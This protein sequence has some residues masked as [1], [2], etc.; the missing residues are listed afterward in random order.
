MN[1]MD[2][3]I[4]T[5]QELA[6]ECI[7]RSREAR[8]ERDLLIQLYE[9]QKNRY[10]VFR[11]T[12]FD[13]ILAEKMY[14]NAVSGSAIL[15]IRYWRTGRHIP[16]DREQVLRF[17]QALGLEAEEQNWLMQSWADKSDRVFMKSD[18]EVSL[19]RCRKK[20]LDGYAREFLDK[21]APERML[22]ANVPAGNPLPYLRHLY[23][24]EALDYTAAGERTVLPGSHSISVNYDAEFRRHMNLS[25]EIPRSAVI[26]HLFLFGMPFLTVD[27]L[28]ERLEQ[29]GYLPLQEN[30]TGTRG[31]RTDYL[32]IR[33]LERYRE[34]C[35]EKDPGVCIRW[36]KQ[37]C[38]AMD[39]TFE[40]RGMGALC[41]LQ[42]KAL[43]NAVEHH[44]EGNSSGDSKR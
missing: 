31:E 44:S 1:K 29:L 2:T 42:F 20:A 4:L 19:Y 39:H 11:K 35:E 8:P 43:K 30:H 13:R 14:Q 34:A 3:E 6:E 23:F 7:R 21:V 28:S 12:D 15:K 38:R 25:G 40:S 26:R 24:L 5:G 27:L 36:M 18:T 10:G 41:F 16:A 9:R 17:G 33:L 37:V 22:L 32:V